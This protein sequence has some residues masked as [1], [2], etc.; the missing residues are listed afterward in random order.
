[1]LD[2]RSSPMPPSDDECETCAYCHEAI[3]DEP[4]V[5][6]NGRDTFDGLRHEH[7][8]LADFYLQVA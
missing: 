2:S 4:S 3:G 6:L 1:M 8:V 5:C 7:C